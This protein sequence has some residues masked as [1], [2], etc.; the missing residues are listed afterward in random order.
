MADVPANGSLQTSETFRENWSDRTV[1]RVEFCGCE[2]RNC[3]FERTVFSDCSFEDCLFDTCDLTLAGIVGS[4]FSSVTFRNCKLHGIAWHKVGFSFDASFLDSQLDYSSFFGMKLNKIRF[5]GSRLKEVTF[6]DAVAREA[7]F[8]RCE[9]KDTVFLQTD[10]SRADFTG[11]RNYAIDVRENQV[12]GAKFDL[13][14]AVSLL[15]SF[16]IRI[17]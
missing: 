13:P 3:T 16:G 10:L 14:E 11:A 8:S 7:D 12:K 9:F 2:F 6:V 17:V 1:G 15:S 4:S 5:T